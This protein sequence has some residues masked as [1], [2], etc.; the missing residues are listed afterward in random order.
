MTTHALPPVQWRCLPFDGLGGHELYRLLQ[1]RSAV[2]VVEQACV[3]QDL[4]GL[5]AQ[6]FHLLGEVATANVADGARSAQL[7]ACARLLPAGV[8]FAEASIGR[9]ATA[10]TARGSGLGHDLMAQACARLAQLWGPQAIRIGAQAHLQAYYGRH[11]F[12]TDGD[13]YLED[14]I[15][16]VE[17]L[18]PA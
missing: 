16:H 6:A 12:V 3:F 10:T 7:L 18:K 9:V 14:G 4:D 1:L 2:F 8:A 5:D 17:M 15:W 11:G 13:P